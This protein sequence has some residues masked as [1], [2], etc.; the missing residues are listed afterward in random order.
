MQSRTVLFFTVSA[1]AASFDVSVDPSTLPDF[2]LPQLFS[3]QNFSTQFN[4][5]GMR[6]ALTSSSQKIRTIFYN[7][8]QAHQTLRLRSVT[9][10]D[11][12]TPVLSY[13]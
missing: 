12:G 6:S 1:E 2:A 7:G 11:V 8:H 10:C 13:V 4:A 9:T 5:N 3:C